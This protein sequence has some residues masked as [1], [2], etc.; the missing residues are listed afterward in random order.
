M[1]VPVC[2]T[3]CKQLE[4]TAGTKLG[5]R[6]P[7]RHADTDQAADGAS[8][9]YAGEGR[10]GSEEGGQLTVRL[11]SMLRLETWQLL[12]FPRVLLHGTLR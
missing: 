4:S 11:Q 8:G 10:D 7:P 3:P 2:G 12:R 6:F 9:I 1:P 5:S